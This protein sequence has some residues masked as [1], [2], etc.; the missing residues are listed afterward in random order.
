MVN[1]VNKCPSCGFNFKK[2]YNASVEITE[3]V[4]KRNKRLKD[5]LK[6]IAV[7]INK[8]VPSS[9]RQSYFRF[10]HSIKET[11]DHIVSWAIENFYQNRHYINGKGFSY[12][13]SMI[14]NRDKNMDTL[15]KNERKRIGG[16]PPVIKT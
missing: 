1:K 11:D 12:L 10:L 7:L 13:R 3:L 15:K 8:H 4:K 2:Q 16:V 14:Q 6:K 5:S 9:D